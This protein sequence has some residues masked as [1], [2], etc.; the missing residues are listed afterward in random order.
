MP[1]APETAVYGAVV[2]PII[3]GPP[4]TCGVEDCPRPATWRIHAEDDSEDYAYY[5]CAGQG[6]LIVMIRLAILD[7]E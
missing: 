1:A 6:D 5:A 2:R 4:T 7:A 3:G